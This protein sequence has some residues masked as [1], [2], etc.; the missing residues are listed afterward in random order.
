MGAQFS[1][2]GFNP[3]RLMASVT[4][5]ID[6]AFDAAAGEMADI[7]R[8]AAER[9]QEM[10]LA[11]ETPTGLA[12]VAAG[13]AYA[14]RYD[15]GLFHNSVDY[16][17]EID[18]DARVITVRFGWLHQWRDY[19]AYQ[20]FGTEHIVRVGALGDTYTWGIAQLANVLRGLA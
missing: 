9:M 1:F 5:W 17:V 7:G 19:F 18:H 12:R 10:I 11:A 8:R 14:G 2:D 6:D 15:E 4:V 16:D 13:G 20:E 3:E